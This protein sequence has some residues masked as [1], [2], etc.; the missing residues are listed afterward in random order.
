MSIVIEI[1]LG[2]TEF[3]FRSWMFGLPHFRNTPTCATLTAFGF[4]FERYSV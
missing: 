1:E 2:K 3:G 4:Y